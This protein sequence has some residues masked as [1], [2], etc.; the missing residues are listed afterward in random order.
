MVAANPRDESVI[1]VRDIVEHGLPPGTTIVAGEAGVNREVTWAM[2]LRPAP[3]AF[4]HISG[5]E[6]ILLPDGVLDLI[7][8]RLSLADAI[9]QLSTFGI[10]ALAVTSMPD[11]ASCTAANATSIPLLVLPRSVDFSHLERETSRAIAER[12]RVLQQ[13]S[14]DIGR[15]LME[16][17]ISGDALEDLTAELARLSGRAVVIER[18]DG[19]VLAF[20]PDPDAT[21]TDEIVQAILLQ[22]NTPAHAWLRIPG[23]SRVVEPPVRAWQAGDAWSRIVAPISSRNGLLGNVSLLAPADDERS[24]DA[25]FASRAATALAVALAREQVAA[26]VRREVEL[27]VLDEMLDGALRSEISLSQQARRL[28]HDLDQEFCTLN[29]RIDPAQ[30]GPTRTRDGRWAVL[31][32]GLRDARRALRLDLL[33]RVRNTSAEVV[34][35]T[36][37]ANAPAEVAKQVHAALESALR[38]HGLSEI[39]S[40]GIGRPGHGIQ[41]I[42]QSYQEARQALTLGRRL[43]RSGHVTDFDTLGIY[44]LILAAEHMPELHAFQEETLG[45]LLNY[46]RVHRSNL[47]ETMDAFFA[48]NCSPKEAASILNVHRNTVLYRLD[49]VADVTGLD[50]DDPDTR[51]RLHLALHVR[52]ALGA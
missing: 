21:V 19:G 27:N 16:L 46:D 2:R 42:R 39:V 45:A 24:E 40:I 20:C 43:N 6:I 37:G 44:R 25:V 17:A 52:M 33:W 11:T 13:Q 12:R 41:G 5:G 30:D 14:Q 26:N 51:L 36:A 18:R 28:G 7:D 10:A 8:E 4:A 48:A 1:T 3:P 35:P 29:A 32:D 23:A 50:L 15:Q 34:W 38:A 22:T 47:T 9:R 31:E 49:R